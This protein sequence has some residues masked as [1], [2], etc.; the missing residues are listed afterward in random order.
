MPKI[1]FT[2]VAIILLNLVPLLGN[3]ILFTNYKT[4]VLVVA[5][6]MLWLSQPAFKSNEAVANRQSDR[7]SI[8]II[9]ICS[10]ASV[11]FANIEWAYFNAGGLAFTT[12]SLVGLLLLL[13]GIIVRVWAIYTLGKHFTATATINNDH[14]LITAG[15]YRFVR[16]PS[17]LGAFM[18]VVGTPVF[19]NGSWSVILALTAMSVAYYIRI[20]AE[21]KMLLNYFGDKYTVYTRHTKRII[22]FIW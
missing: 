2:I 18:A 21:E 10:S 5:A 16:H 19:L 8:V 4:W 9:L 12:V 1:V 14:E 15:P 13:L 7:F 17:Y 3:P 22:P 20:T 6:A 11:A